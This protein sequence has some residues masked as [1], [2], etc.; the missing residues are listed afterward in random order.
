MRGYVFRYCGRFVHLHTDANYFIV[1]KGTK[2]PRKWLGSGKSG[3]RETKLSKSYRDS[4]VENCIVTEDLY[5]DKKSPSAVGSFI[6]GR[7]APAYSILEV[8]L[9]TGDVIRYCGEEAFPDGLPRK[10]DV[11]FKN[12]TVDF[13]PKNPE[14]EYSKIGMFNSK[15]S[16]KFRN[17][18]NTR[19]I[20]LP[21]E[22]TTISTNNGITS[23]AYSGNDY[24]LVKFDIHVED[25]ELEIII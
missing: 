18:S 16:V 11:S 21:L 5:F 19:G 3:S 20:E 6:Y 23:I 25:L 1:P 24:D 14:V 22:G 13:N 15:G 12:D 4:K 9:D 2:V 7:K 17:K 10:I 8:D